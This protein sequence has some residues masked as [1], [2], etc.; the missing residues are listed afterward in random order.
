MAGTLT[1]RPAGEL[2][3]AQVERL[4][5]EWYPLVDAREPELVIVDLADEGDVGEV[6]NN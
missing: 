1:L 2:A 5:P 6:R 4:R 3:I